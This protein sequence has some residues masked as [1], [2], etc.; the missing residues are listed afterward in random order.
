MT[1]RQHQIG[2]TLLVASTGGHLEQL[3]RLKDR[4][5]PASDGVQWVTFDDPQARSLLANESV[6]YVR[7]V[8]PRDYRAVTANLWAAQRILREHRIER[9]VSTGSGIAL[10]FLP[11]ARLSGIPCHYIESAARAEGPSL[12]GSLASRIPGVRLYAQYPRWAS[13][14]WQYR[15]SLFDRYQAYAPEGCSPAPAARRVVV[16]LGTMR[17]YG[18]RRAL[19][20]LARVLPE[21][22]APQ[23]EIL[24]QT[25]V[26]DASGLGIDARDKVP[27]KELHD[28]IVAADLVVAHAGIG[29]A[30]TALDLGKAPVLLT[31]RQRHG[32]HVD[33][34]QLMIAGELDRRGLAVSRDPGDLT[35]VDL[36]TA[37]TTGITADDTSRP[38]H[39]V[40]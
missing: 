25:G 6:E 33:D 17:T 34:H 9:V 29:S 3:F 22:S 12:T 20:A 8:A 7:Y 23:A 36:V 30:L 21:V 15:G 5:T 10:S 37:M 4:F 38:F 11:A 31:R 19:D 18:F 40:R 32:E 28:A 24:W 13:D 27:A 1:E 26:T 2:K 39:L 35:A 16:T 14:R